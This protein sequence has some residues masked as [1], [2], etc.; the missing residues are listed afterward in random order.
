MKALLDEH[1]EFLKS[2]LIPI[3]LGV[4]TEAGWPVVVSLWFLYE[5]GKILCATG[6]SAR[7]VSY[8]AQDDR[9][10]FEIAE[11]RPPYCGVRGQARAQL[12]D[13]RGMEVLE[14][15]LVRYLG[16]TDNQLARTLLNRQEPD[17]AI[18]LEPVWVSSWNFSK[19][20]SDVAPPGF[21]PDQ[22]CCPS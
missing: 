4:H 7:I 18:I 10:G 17:T 21:G 15:L 2:I 16:G 5:E 11:D 1:K 20:M 3:R 19:R 12:D 8:L 6:K 22:K 14:R 13:S 9:C